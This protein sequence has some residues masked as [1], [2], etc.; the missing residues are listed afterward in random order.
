MLSDLTSTCSLPFP[1]SSF[2]FES[3]SRT[4]RKFSCDMY[5]NGFNIKNIITQSV[6]TI[7]L[8][9]IIWLYY[10]INAVKDM[11]DVEIAEDYSNWDK[12]KEFFKPEDTEKL[13]EMLLVSHAIVTAFNLGK[14]VIKKSPWEINITEIIAVIKYGI[15]VVKQNEVRNSEVS[16]LLRNAEEIHEKWIEIEEIFTNNEILSLEQMQKTLIIE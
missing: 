9:I 12:V 15:K 8:E 10:S 13:N 4:L 11:A 14:I 2:L 16:K 1:G 7:I 5:R 3:N 6:S